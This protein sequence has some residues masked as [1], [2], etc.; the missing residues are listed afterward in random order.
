MSHR[1]LSLPDLDPAYSEGFGMS[2][3]KTL[4]DVDEENAGLF[5]DL[6]NP[7][8]FVRLDWYSMPERVDMLER[9][10]RTLRGFWD[11]IEGK[12]KHG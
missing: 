5:P 1:A 6:D 9:L 12:V 11:S 2:E 7:D 3:A 8:P 10:L 4:D